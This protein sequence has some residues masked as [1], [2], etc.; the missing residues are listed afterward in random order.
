MFIA[1]L[2]AGA[3][4]ALIGAGD[5]ALAD[6]T[7]PTA[8]NP[9]LGDSCG[10]D[11]VLVLDESGSIDTS[12]GQDVEDAYVALLNGLVDTNSRVGIVVFSTT[13]A[14]ALGYTAVAPGNIAGPL[15][16]VGYNPPQDF[17][18]WQAALE[19]VGTFGSPDLVVML[20][21]GNPTAYNSGGSVV[22]GEEPPGPELDNAVTAANALKAGGAHVLAVGVSSAP[23]VENL[24]AISGPNSAP[25]SAVNSSTIQGL[26]VITASF[27]N[28]ETAMSNLASALCDPGVNLSKSADP[29]S[30]PENGGDFTFTL[31]VENVSPDGEAFTITSLTDDQSGDSA[32]FSACAALVGLP[33]EEGTSISC[34]YTVAHSAI[35]VY[36]NNAEVHVI[37]L[38]ERTGSDTASASV[39]V[40]NLPSSIGVT[41]IADVE[42]LGQSGGVVMFAVTVTNTSV[43]DEVVI[44]SLVDDIY[45]D[46]TDPANTSLVSTTCDDDLPA[47]LAAAGGSFTCTFA[48]TIAGPPG[49]YTDTVTA[50]GVDDDDAVV[51]GESSETV[52]IPVVASI[53]IEKTPEVASV[54][55]RKDHTFTITVINTGNVTLTEVAVTDVLVPACDASL[56]SMAPGVTTSHTCVVEDVVTQIDNEAIVLGLAPDSSEVTD[57]DIATVFPIAPSALVG[58]FVWNDKDEDG[59]Q[60][61]GEAGIPN[62]KV[63]LI[64]RDTGS[65]LTETTNADGRYLFS[66]VEEGNY[67]VQIVLAS[68]DG[69]LTT[70][71]SFTFFLPDGGS[72]L[73]ADFGIVEV[74]PVTGV[75]TGQVAWG[76]LILLAL[77]ALMV[78]G[79]ALLRR[80]D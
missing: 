47:T 8:P 3:G 52:T 66:A 11:I 19:D 45:A 23:S 70:P 59:K 5:A 37:D 39:E 50:S 41:K 26:D 34:T 6:H 1:V 38:T 14:V 33:V 49:D 79:G 69:D 48:V 7:V 61:S 46:V 55:F 28:L 58:D 78:G 73:T 62:A 68:V 53:D 29:I 31:T 75:E 30:L 10:I 80:E 40:T 9:D 12:E 64:N 35:G 25:P 22:V 21:D 74:L 67:R 57:S 77:G 36:A 44:S 24:K 4:I 27:A 60:D 65:M 63:N 71:G 72:Y 16:S 43:A 56:G 18:N 76:G 32:D 15:T 54:I 20:T 13:S 51:E 2:L 17:T 42:T